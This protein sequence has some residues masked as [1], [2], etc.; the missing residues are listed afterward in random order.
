MFIELQPLMKVHFRVYKPIAVALTTAITILC[1]QQKAIADHHV[2]IDKEFAATAEGLCAEYS[3][4]SVYKWN[5]GYNECLS[6]INVVSNSEITAYK[7]REIIKTKSW[8]N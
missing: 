6:D 7:S 1:V 4:K 8:M 5:T 2:R 3:I